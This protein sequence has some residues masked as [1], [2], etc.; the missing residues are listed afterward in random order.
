LDDSYK[1]T[2]I[3]VPSVSLIVNGAGD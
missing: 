1:G 3:W 2:L